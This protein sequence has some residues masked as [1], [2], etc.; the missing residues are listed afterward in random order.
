[1]LGNRLDPEGVKS[2][3][4]GR[5]GNISEPQSTVLLMAALR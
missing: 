2:M 5:C 3:K 4:K 1:M